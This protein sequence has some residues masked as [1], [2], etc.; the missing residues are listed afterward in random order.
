[1]KSKN[2][3]VGPAEGPGAGGGPGNRIPALMA[4]SRS[5]INDV[6]SY[7]FEIETRETLWL[8]RV[9]N[10]WA[11]DIAR[12]L[13][14]LAVGVPAVASVLISDDY[15]SMKV[16]DAWRVGISRDGAVIIKVS[17]CALIADDRFL[18]LCVGEDGLYVPIAKSETI[19]WDGTEEYFTPSDIRR[20]V[21]DTLKRILERA[22]WL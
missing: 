1:M 14:K 12:T 5:E 20:M 4:I 11:E 15:I 6:R 8:D 16:T 22:Q 3:Q 9:G 19:T 10:P 2:V 7:M 18:L 13:E 17:D 21:K